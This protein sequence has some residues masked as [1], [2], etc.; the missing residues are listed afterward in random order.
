M[1]LDRGFIIPRIIK[2]LL[3]LL[4]PA[5]EM[6]TPLSGNREHSDKEC[7]LNKLISVNM[8]VIEDKIISNTK[9]YIDTVSC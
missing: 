1:R 8:F 9:F 4:K 2:P 3:A 5:R 7:R 6:L